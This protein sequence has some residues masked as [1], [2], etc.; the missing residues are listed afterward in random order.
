MWNKLLIA[1]LVLG[2]AF[3]L[4]I[5]GCRSKNSAIEP[6]KSRSQTLAQV[7]RPAEVLSEVT[8]RPRAQPL[9]QPVP[10]QYNRR[11]VSA[12]VEPTLAMANVQA[13]PRPLAVQYRQPVAVPQPV[14]VHQPVVVRYSA[15]PIPDL[16]P[17][18]V[19]AVTTNRPMAEVM[20]VS[21]PALSTPRSLP[22]AGA[23]PAAANVVP[24]NP[25]RAE[26]LQALKPLA[27]LSPAQQQTG[28]AWVSSP[29][30]AMGRVN[31]SRR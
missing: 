28:N 14:T 3:G 5:S 2:V 19:Y 7:S 20:V 31:A 17:A 29:S 10:V 27:V 12:P 25:S 13:S 1:I 6:S 24:H 11:S 18:R 8:Y 15:A 16:E 23:I 9:P 26:A 30:T 22:A 21:R 4:T